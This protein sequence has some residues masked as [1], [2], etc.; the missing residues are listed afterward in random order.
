MGER[1]KGKLIIRTFMYY[2][3]RLPVEFSTDGYTSR[4][5]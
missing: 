3:R 2:I 4:L 5:Y 1:E